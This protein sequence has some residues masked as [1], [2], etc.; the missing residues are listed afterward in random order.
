MT[1]EESEA[2]KTRIID[3]EEVTREGDILDV[4]KTQDYG[5]GDT[6]KYDVSETMYIETGLPSDDVSPTM[7]IE[8]G[9]PT[10]D[11]SE[12]MYIETGLPKDDV[13]ATKYIETGLPKDD[14]SST[15]YIE[16]GLPTDDI[17]KTIYAEK[18]LPSAAEG[19]AY[20]QES[21][22][23]ETISVDMPEDADEEN[24][25]EEAAESGGDEDASSEDEGA[26]GAA[27]DGEE[28][29]KEP[30]PDAE[31]E[32][33]R[34]KIKE[35]KREKKRRAIRRRNRFWTILTALLLLIAGFIF[36]LSGFFTVD[37]IE[38]EGNSHFSDEEIINIAHAVPGH[39]LIYNPDKA[40]II[41]YLLQNP[42]IKSADV[43]R[44][45]PSTLVITVEER[46]QACAFKYDND[47]LVMDDEGILLKKTRTEPKITMVLGLVVSKMQLGQTIGTEN[48]YMFSKLLKLIRTMKAADLYFVTID[49]S[50]YQDDKSVTA[51]I[52]DKLMIKADYDVLVEN[53][54]NGRLHKIVEKLF[55]D[56]VQ[57]GTI[58][59]TDDGSPSFEPGI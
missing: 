17:S 48:Q 44:K 38:V 56:E 15:K 6:S 4:E 36:S 31:A 46:R 5:L 7:Y 43:K 12:T 25:T 29:E 58:Y 10:D 32:E 33:I 59:F 34:K 41:E 2:K 19:D 45:L 47:Y 22:T 18:G 39:N 30:D 28:G 24:A 16:T 42:Y 51:Y 37:S 57:R 9:L 23:D 55:E 26:G 53:L 21:V 49:M 11:V 54:D 35:R 3:P 13:S 27:D 20:N 52:Y 50:A 14:V 1:P 40:E 8:T